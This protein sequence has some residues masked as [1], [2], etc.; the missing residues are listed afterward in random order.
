VRCPVTLRPIAGKVIRGARQ[1]RASIFKHWTLLKRL[2]ARRQLRRR[3]VRYVAYGAA[4]LTGLAVLIEVKVQTSFAFHALFFSALLVLT[5]TLIL[6]RRQRLGRMRVQEEVFKRAQLN[7][8]QVCCSGTENPLPFLRSCSSASPTASSTG[9]LLEKRETFMQRQEKIGPVDGSGFS[10]SDYLRVI[11]GQVRAAMKYQLENGRIEDPVDPWDDYYATPCYAHGVAALYVSGYNADPDLLESGWRAMDRALADINRHRPTRNPFRV[12]NY[13]FFTFPLLSALTLYSKIS[14]P[15]RVGRWRN[16]L[17]N[18][19]PYAL[20]YMP[21]SEEANNWNVFNLVGEYLRS[22]EG[23]TSL[24]YVEESLRHQVRHFTPLGMYVEDGYPLAYEQQVRYL[25]AVMLQAGYQGQHFE[26]VRDNVYAGTWL[27]LFMQ[28]PLGDFPTGYR[29][30]HHLWNEAQAV[31][32]YETLATQSAMCGMTTEAQ[33]YKR[34]ARL[35]FGVVNRWIRPNGSGCIVKNWYPIRKRHGYETYSTHTTYNMLACSALAVAWAL[36][37]DAINEGVA[38]ADV[39]GFVLSVV[40]PF[41]KVFANAAG[42]FVE[43]DTGGDRGKRQYNPT[44]LLRVHFRGVDSQLGPSDGCTP[45]LNGTDRNIA[46]G[47]AWRAQ[48]GQW[49]TLADMRPP[50]PIVEVLAESATKA[51]FRVH[52]PKL[53]ADSADSVSLT[54]TITVQEDR[55]I[56]EDRIGGLNGGPIRVAYPMLVFDGRERT[57][58]VINGNSVALRKQGRGVRFTIL[59]PQDAQLRRTG[60][61]IPHRNGMVEIAFAEFEGLT[62]TYTVAANR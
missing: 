37:D 3:L 18:I 24:D 21:P 5:G 31:A 29:S 56:I 44:G 12:R 15:E 32:L 10:K 47:P 40:Q 6:I 23:L 13:D 14:S 17:I 57:E 26:E 2:L 4:S 43:Y 61:Q 45:Y 9:F 34:A 8:G 38:P 50:D 42:T 58:V 55:V 11:N 30:S 60:E 59:Q 25:L 16:Q 52:F 1:A 51:S 41:R 39:G 20:Y 49:H 48:D 35:S 19:D 62:A 36:A 46:I 22:K 27:S 7:E 53:H 54:E 28:S 33:V